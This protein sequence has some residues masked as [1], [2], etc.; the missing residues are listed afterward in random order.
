MS[1]VVTKK[2]RLSYLNV[3]EA[4]SQEGGEAKFSVCVIVPKTDKATL[5]KLHA[6]VEETKLEGKTKKWGGKIPNGLKLPIRD[7]DEE[8]P[9]KEEFKNA[10][11]FNASS[12]IKPLVL[13][14]DG[15][16][17][18]DNSELYSGCYGRVSVNLYPYDVSGSKGVA[19]GLNAVKKVA[20]GER[21][22][23]SG[24]SA[25]DFDDDEAEWMK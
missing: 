11:F 24:A 14:T 5:E 20:D 1:K 17:L 16:P 10:Y 13:D 21:L 9:D 4:R 23:G 19:V 7:G 12:K 8:R 2:V 18:L 22:A 3:F 15:E 25:A 6:A